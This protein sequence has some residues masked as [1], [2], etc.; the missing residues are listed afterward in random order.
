MEFE[1]QTSN[2]ADQ[3][4]RSKSYK[5]RDPYSW[6]MDNYLTSTMN[7]KKKQLKKFT[8][9]NIVSNDFLGEIVV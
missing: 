5:K 3:R 9:H 6:Q 4:D 7:E 2:L 8:N 1:D